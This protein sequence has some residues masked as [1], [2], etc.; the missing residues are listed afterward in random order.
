M[1][2]VTIKEPGKLEIVEAKKPAIKP[3]QALV[4]TEKVAICNATDGKLLSGHFP[5]VEKYP[6]VLGHE[7]CGIVE[8]MGNKVR[9]FQIG[10]RVIGGLNFDFSDIGCESGWGGFGEYTLVNDHDAMVA[11][12]VANKEN[13]WF[14]VYEIQRAVDKGI[15]VNEA[16]MLCTWREVLGAFGDF[17]LTKADKILIFGAGP[18]GLSFVKFGKLLGIEWIGIVDPLACKRKK[19]MEMGADMAFDP[20]DSE[21]ALFAENNT[22]FLT[23]IIDA[24]GKPS[25][26]NM[27]L[28]MIKM[29]GSVCVYGVISR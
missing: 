3:Y 9:N 11:D 16:V 27:A 23:A 24:V 25:I 4:K 13:G 18:V 5:G 28:P 8:A 17:N 21:L 20:S 29:G 1:K 26:I 6:L 15:Q 14:E 19:A 12:G 10:D 2:V 7:G 22:K